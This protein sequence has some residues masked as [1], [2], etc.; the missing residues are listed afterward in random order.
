MLIDKITNFI[1]TTDKKAYQIS[2]DTGIS[3]T[4]IQEVKTGKR[5][6]ENIT[7]KTAEKLLKYIDELE[8]SK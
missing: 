5:K 4:V 3:A 2:R 6:V 8:K 1:N 7:L